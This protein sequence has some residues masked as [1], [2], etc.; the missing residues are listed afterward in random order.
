MR[1]SFD[2]VMENILKLD[3]P[4]ELGKLGAQARKL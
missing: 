1:V 4:C 3:S 2:R